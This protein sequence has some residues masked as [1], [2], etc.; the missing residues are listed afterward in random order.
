LPKK[1]SK[2]LK[3]KLIVAYGTLANINQT[4]KPNSDYNPEL[5][6]ELE[7]ELGIE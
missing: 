3:C 1:H 7:S 5:Y 2:K 6:Q 4:R